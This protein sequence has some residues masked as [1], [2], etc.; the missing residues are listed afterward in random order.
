MKKILTLLAAASVATFSLQTAVAQDWPKQPIRMMVGANPGGG[1]DLMARAIALKLGPALNVAIVVDNKPGA[2]NTIAADATAKSTDGHTMVMGVSTA[3]G[4]APHLLKLNYDSNKDLVPV[5]FVSSV[6]NVLVVNKDLPVRNVAEFV[7]F[8]KSQAGKV[9]YASSGA[10]STQHI[11]AEIFKDATGVDINHIPYR[12]SAPALTDLLGGRVESSFD[13][14]PSI[15]SHIRSG[16][17]KALAVASKTRNAQI[18]D[19]PTMEQAGVKNVEMSAW[20]GI[21]MPASTP[22]AIQ[23]RVHSEVNKILATADTKSRLEAIGADITIMSQAQFAAFHD[24]E[25]K[26]YGELIRRKN[27]KVD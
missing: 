20:Y 21:Y 1:T 18:P 10:G 17:V 2:S 14:L 25:F 24:A 9:N 8:A 16:S 5:V 26:R 22:K 12:G 19:V 13:T 27:I 4:I 23:D 6:P 11:A 3:H 15:I 7:S